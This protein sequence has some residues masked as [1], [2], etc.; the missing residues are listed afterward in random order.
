MHM[1]TKLS[2]LVHAG[3]PSKRSDD[4]RAR[5]LAE[6]YLG[7]TGKVISEQ[8]YR[9]PELAV[10]L[11][12]TQHHND[13]EEAQD[14][15][16]YPTQLLRSTP[17]AREIGSEGSMSAVQPAYDDTTFLEDTQDAYAALESQLQTSSLEIP[18]VTPLKRRAPESFDPDSP[19]PEDLDGHSPVKATYQL[20]VRDEV[21]EDEQQSQQ[22]SLGEVSVQQ[23][24][25]PSTEEVSRTHEPSS[26]VVERPT[27]KPRLQQRRIPAPPVF[28]PFRPPTM[29][30]AVS[31][32]LRAV[33]PELPAQGLRPE[34]KSVSQTSE[35]QDSYLK[36][37]ILVTPSQGWAA[38]AQKPRMPRAEHMD[39]TGG[40][41]A[42]SVHVPFVPLPE[43][44]GV[45]VAYV[46]DGQQRDPRTPG[47]VVEVERHSQFSGS[48]PDTTSELPTSYSLSD[49]TSQSSRARARL[50]ESQRSASDPGVINNGHGSG[51]DDQRQAREDD[52]EVA[53]ARIQPVKQ[54]LKPV[55]P[56]TS[57][58]RLHAVD[59]EAVPVAKA[60]ATP[61]LPPTAISLTNNAIRACEPAA[62]SLFADLPLTIRPPEPEVA[63]EGFTT[64]ITPT[65]SWLAS[66]DRIKDVYTPVSVTRDIR[67]LERGHWLVDTSAWST[68]V[69]LAL[70]KFL[71]DMVGTGNAGWGVWCLREG[72][73]EVFGKVQVF[74][75]GEVVK[76][77]YLMFSSGPDYSPI[78]MLLSPSVLQKSAE[79]HPQII[80][81]IQT[82]PSP[83]ADWS[84]APAVKN[85]MAAVETRALA[86]LGPPEP[87]LKE[88]VQSIPMRDG[89]QSAIKIH[90][91]ASKPSGGSPL[92]V[93][94]YR[95]GFVAGSRDQLTGTA[96][97]FVRQFGAVVVNISYRMGPEY[98]WNDAWDSVKWIAEHTAELGAD[99]R[100]GFIVGGLS[101]GACSSLAI[102]NLAVLEELRVPITG[103]WLGIPALMD[104]RHV[105]GEYREY[106]L[107]R[108]Q[109]AHAP[110][111][112]VAA[113]AALSELN[114]WDDDS[115]L[116]FPVLFRDQVPLSSLPPTYFQVCGAD[117]VR[118]DALI[119]DEML[120][121]AGVKTKVDF[122]PGC[123]HGH[124]AF[125]PG[126]EVSEKAGVDTMVGVGWLLGKEVSRKEGGRSMVGGSA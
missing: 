18:D 11:Q 110:T 74:C 88:S 81:F 118:D 76:H 44:D 21:V 9:I 105:P 102:A 68:Q 30:R 63:I 67:P 82:H 46:G 92:I 94:L 24:Q 54:D 120:K 40:P 27:K 45:G 50:R 126:I 56:K 125:M 112:D 4:D 22:I 6:A 121:E 79:L 71:E 13:P 109:N 78:K 49:I 91:P 62:R 83:K 2:L 42:L 48:A 70:W 37:P 66:S 85:L 123:P 61:V 1:V 60:K 10:S 17:P 114:G 39:R 90:R 15:T 75:W 108:E 119:Y 72:D 58:K 28:K 77:V 107:A 86:Q 12:A 34:R 84:D 115:P 124:W 20:F 113:L 51:G 38:K 104:E 97:G 69:Q 116:R 33:T 103:L 106:F 26:Q 111:L 29:H 87:S 100:L 23:S 32:Q 3:A 47:Q 52:G 43:D 122:Y 64:H 101:A 65:L 41:L 53:L 14:E 19:W 93:L 80:D 8:S 5:A 57:E 89:Y 73:G 98:K 117:P 35:S 55:D 59:E 36:T 95:G 96:R 16:H 99:P 31:D 25:Q 7:F